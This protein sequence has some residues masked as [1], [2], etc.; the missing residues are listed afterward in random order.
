[1]GK[2]KEDQILEDE[3][4]K[5]MLQEEMEADADRIWA[6][7]NSDPSLKD[8]VAPQEM[9]DKL[10]AK[11]WTMD[12]SEMLEYLGEPVK[13]EEPEE[14]EELE[15][16]AELSKEEQE[17]IELGRIYKK[18]R[19]WNKVFVLIAAV[20]VALAIGMTSFGVPQRVVE[21]VNRMV[22]GREQ[23]KINVDSDRTTPVKATDEEKALQ[24]IEDEFGVMPVRMMYLP[25]KVQFVESVIEEES[26][27]ARLYYEKG[28]EQMISCTM[29]FNYRPSTTGVDVEDSLIKEYEVD[30]KNS[31][32]VV[33]QYDVEGTDK[34]RYRVEFEYQNVQYMIMMSGLS[35][36]EVNKVIESL[37]FFQ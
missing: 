14:E 32:I 28:T 1:M 21:K 30:N 23:E 11:I 9:Q 5:R 12:K 26:Q 31:A 29:W 15:P 37:H 35:D 2:Q 13:A 33:K 36:T 8:V 18:K 24:Q 20:V 34:T 25:K 7:V 3:Q 19:K 16:V 10:F 17:L 4:L 27:N 22:E 6:K